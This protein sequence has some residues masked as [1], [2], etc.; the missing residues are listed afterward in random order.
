M[1]KLASPRQSDQA[2]VGHG[3]AQVL[4][5]DGVPWYR[6]RHLI[7][8]NA[9]AYSLSLLAAANGFDGTMM[10]GLQALPA[11]Q[12]FM[13]H[14]T[15]AWLGFIGA[16]Q[17]LS[18]TIAYPII[19]YFANRW[20]RKKGLFIGFAFLFLGTFLQAFAP[21]QAA[22]ILGRFFLG[23]PSAWWGGLSPLIIT[24]I[25]YPTHRAFLTS[26]YNSGWYVGSLL[27]AWATFGTR[28][29][30]DS[31]AWRIPSILQAAIPVMVLP[32]A[33]L[34]PESPRFLISQGKRAEAKKILT[35]FHAGGDENSALV[36]FELEEIETA[37]QAE[38]DAASSTSW[39]DLFR[40]PGNRHRAAISITL[41]VFAQWNG[42]GVVS[43]YLALVLQT[44]GITSVTDQTLISGCLQIWNLIFAVGAAAFVDRLGRRPLFLI[45]S[46]GMLVSFILISGLS[47]SFA[48]TGNAPTG[49]A[50]I[51][52]LFIYY[53]FY[54]IAFTPLVVSYP[55]EI[56]SYTLRARGTAL[57][58]M[59]TYAAIFFNTFV[60]PIALADIGWKYYVVFA[61]ILVV[62]TITIYFLY[63]ETR[64]HTLE[65]MAVVFGDG[66]AV[67]EVSKDVKQ[68][69][70]ATH[71][72]TV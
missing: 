12:E 34:V 19:A 21:N 47:G 5:Q 65:E 62:V 59:S 68:N 61:V 16:A 60:N 46:I 27:A 72:E 39:M 50:V 38:K 48:T 51:P 45:S 4:P 28:N 44:V 67:A 7:I 66:D 10:N 29:Y 32:F 71:K 43:Y 49:L 40:T 35:K 36:D 33:I 23:Q 9:Y 64:G 13:N 15:G 58:Q 1:G 53:A 25:A 2:A 3:L 41:G 56:W 18:S 55:A 17:A 11:W 8:L 31:W 70:E 54:D 52:F 26:L 22:F 24:E 37:I 6:K 30:S 69:V 20:G 14:P 42:V 63:P 57:T